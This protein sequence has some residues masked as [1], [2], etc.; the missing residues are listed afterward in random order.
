MTEIVTVSVGQAGNQISDEFWQ[1]IATEHRIGLNGLPL[2]DKV[3]GNSE[4]F[5]NQVGKKF[6][7]RA[8]LIDLE[9]AVINDLAEK[10]Q[11]EFY[12]PQNLVHGAD[13]AG[14]NFAVGHNAM[15]GQYIENALEKIK[16]EVERTDTLG[17]FIATHSVGG[18]TGS[19]FG[20]LIMQ[21][22]KEQY[23]QVPLLSFSIYPSPRIS[24]VLTEPY[25]AIFSTY[26]LVRDTNATIVLD[27]DGIYKIA[28]EQLGIANPT[29][30]DLNKLISQSMVNLTSGMRFSGTLNLDLRKLVTNMVPHPRLHFLLTST[31]PLSGVSDFE[32]LS[33]N[34]IAQGLFKSTN[35]MAEVN[36]DDGAYISSTVMFRGAVKSAEID[37]SM[38]EIKE[39]LKFVD[40]MPTGF[41]VGLSE[42]PPQGSDFAAAMVS[43]HTGIIQVFNRILSQFDRL[44]SKKAFSHW[45]TDAGFTED[46]IINARD[47]IAALVSEY[48]A[49][50]SGTT[51]KEAPKEIT[52]EPEGGAPQ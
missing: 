33:V 19:G 37:E 14:N 16:A 31:A 13:G 27:N 12:N 18:G 15:G 35:I 48:E 32:G 23:P 22:I 29:Y 24:D 36:P 6:V 21:N 50:L 11:S 47:D 39:K 42:P 44:W 40:W 45:Y 5:F 10:K 51:K 26:R 25:N 52:V 43:N 46:D 3:K 38:R 34:Q 30:S 41:K 9:P 17:G 8:V 1:Q 4:V 49:A 28:Q 20:T 2:E 7:P